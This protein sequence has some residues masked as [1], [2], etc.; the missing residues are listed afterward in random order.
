MDGGRAGT[1]LTTMTNSSPLSKSFAALIRLSGLASKMVLAIYMGK[2]LPLAD[3]GAYGLV[4][5]AVMMLFGVLG[6]KFDFVVSRDI[7]TASPLVAARMIRDQA[8]LYGSNYL[9]VAAVGLVVSTSHV[10]DIP[11]WQIACVVAI[12]IFES[13]A[14]TLGAILTSLQR[15]VTAYVVFFIRSSLWVVPAVGLGLLLPDF[16]T[17]SVVLACWAGGGLAS[18]LAAGF[19]L[20]DLPWSKAASLAI[21]TPWIVRGIRKSLLILIGTTSGT[22]GFYV[23]RFVVMHFLGVEAVGVITLYS[24]FANALVALVDSGVL[25]FTYPRLIKLFNEGETNRYWRTVRNAALESLVLGAVVALG[26]GVAVPAMGDV[27]HRPE[28]AL[29]KITLWLMLLGL[30]LRAN[31]RVFYYILYSR[32]QDK[33]LWL[34][35]MIYIIPSLGGNILFVYLFGLPGI[36]YG[37]IASSLYLFFWQGWWVGKGAKIS[38]SAQV[39]IATDDT[40]TASRPLA[41]R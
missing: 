30:W 33:G 11:S 29:N 3:V 25:S 6:L 31:V 18:L 15:Q 17:A 12:A 21:D 26:M 27:F 34:G 2:F 38:S 10:T 9:V 19:F 8:V 14:S 32:H 24:S 40:L 35:D 23:D 20:R 41:G 39:D 16:R 37:T 1:T 28:L 4:F 22:I 36:G 5:G 13:S 7:V